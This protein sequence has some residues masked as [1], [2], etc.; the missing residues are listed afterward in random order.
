[1]KSKL[2]LAASILAATSALAY[3]PKPAKCPDAATIAAGGLSKSV[4]AK[5]QNGQWVVGMMKSKYD[6]KDNWTFVV[7]R[8]SA[9][10]PE[11]AYDKATAALHSLKYQQGPVAM[12]QIS[13]WGCTYSNN[14][15]YAAIAVTPSLEGVAITS[16]THAIR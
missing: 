14:A 8:I 4:I 1:M 2:L 16:I 13:K 6:T 15:N 12:Q 11:D 10:G 7:G 9:T 3:P 5:D